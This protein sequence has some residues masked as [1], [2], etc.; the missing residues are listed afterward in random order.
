VVVLANFSG[1]A[2]TAYEI[3]LP[4]AGA[5]RVRLNSD[6]KKYGADYAGTAT[7]DV[8]AKAGSY[9]GFAQKGTVA[10]G[11]YSVVVLSQ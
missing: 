11:P 7:A 1:K 6:D 4:R 2:F 10:I 3:G 5:W 8:T 9:D